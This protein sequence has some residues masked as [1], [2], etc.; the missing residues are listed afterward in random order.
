VLSPRV[1]AKQCPGV[2]CDGVHFGSAFEDKGCTRSAFLFDR[3]VTS[4]MD[5][6]IPDKCGDSCVE[7]AE[8]RYLACCAT[9]QVC[10]VV[11]V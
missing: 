7:K 4:L 8:A 2:R 1:V 5:N 6:M 9:K 10:D 3:V 11:K